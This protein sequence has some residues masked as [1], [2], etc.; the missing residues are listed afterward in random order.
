M[1][2][3][4]TEAVFSATAATYDAAR[5]K[6]IPGFQSFYAAAVDL[7][8][9]G[10]ETILDLGAGTGLLSAFVRE[11]LPQTSLHLIDNSEPMLAQARTR[12]DG[13]QRI[14]F[15]L[16]DY[17]KAPL[18]EAHYD[19][20]V[21]ALSIHHLSDEA[22]QRLFAR[23]LPALK[24]GGLFVNAEQVLQPTQELEFA[25]RERWLTDIRALGANEQQVA[26][27]LL[28]QT[29]D[30]CATIED[31]LTWLSEAGFQNARCVYA[32]GRFAVLVAQR[33]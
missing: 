3:N 27:S 26:D 11:R 14:T 22:K 33:P 25:A 20:A 10:A 1:D 16:A 9:H 23:I 5:A 30:R 7:L 15:E 24:P 21:S 2:S 12:F 19:A 28:R 4:N 17:T 32:N 29:E 18:P 8:P 31:Q 13:V 6:L